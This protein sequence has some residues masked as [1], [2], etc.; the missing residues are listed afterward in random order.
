MA[1]Q[2]QRGS[3]CLTTF[4]AGTVGLVVFGA[5]IIWLLSVIFE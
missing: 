3:D 5:L 2:E 1:S 4:L